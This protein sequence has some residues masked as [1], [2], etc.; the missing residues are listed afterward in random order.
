MKESTK[1]KR[2]QEACKKGSDEMFTRYADIGDEIRHYPPEIFYH[3]KI[4]F[5]C[6]WDVIYKPVTKSKNEQKVNVNEIVDYVTDSTG[7]HEIIQINYD[8]NGRLPR[9][10]FIKYFWNF[11]ARD[12]AKDVRL[13]ASG[14]DPNG[15]FQKENQV[16]CL[17]IDYSKYDWVITNPPFS[18]VTDFLKTLSEE[19]ERR[20]N[21][22]RPFNF[23]LMIPWSSLG[24][25][26][27][28]Y[29]IEKK[30]FPGF[31]KHLSLKFI[32]LEGRPITEKYLDSKTKTEREREDYW[33][34]LGHQY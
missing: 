13:F 14:F 20:K 24:N 31:G 23:I 30:I 7:I 26:I 5:P 2:Y 29:F 33:H 25:S 32:D 4:L 34:L 16:S 12:P 11:F 9:C 15:R 22:N 28:N 27:A 17:T 18:I 3:K 10:H 6:D 8:E 1:L 19:S 21:T